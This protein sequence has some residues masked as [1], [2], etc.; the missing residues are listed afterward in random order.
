M[1]VL[2]TPGN[3]RPQRLHSK[4]ASGNLTWSG[5]HGNLRTASWHCRSVNPSACLEEK[6]AR[7]GWLRILVCS[8]CLDPS[9]NLFFPMLFRLPDTPPGFDVEIVITADVDEAPV[10]EL[11]MDEL[12]KRKTLQRAC[13]HAWKDPG[14]GC[15][16]PNNPQR[17][18]PRTASVRGS[19][20]DYKP[21]SK[22]VG[23]CSQ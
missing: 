17:L 20:A 21:I 18:I 7:L 1:C 8:C 19:G 2:H 9:E 22:S 12:D 6:C 13:N 5:D 14:K 16:I 4:N 3:P 11:D 23:A 10:D 15:I